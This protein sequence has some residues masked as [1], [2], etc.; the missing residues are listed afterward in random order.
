MKKLSL[1]ALPLAL[2]GAVFFLGGCGSQKA[3][4]AANSGA[5][6]PAMA[7][8]QIKGAVMIRNSAFNPIEMTIAKGENIIWMNEDSASHQIASDTNLFSGNS[9]SKGQNYSFTFKD[10][11]TFPYHCAIHPFMKGTIIVK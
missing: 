4:P 2:L 3:A 9:I 7:P 6:A 10:T 8:G 11:G 1:I 5:M